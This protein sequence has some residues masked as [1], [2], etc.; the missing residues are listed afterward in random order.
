MKTFVLFMVTLFAGTAAFAQNDKPQGKEPDQRISVKKEYDDQ[1]NL[2]GYDASCV[3]SWSSDT[4]LAW[5]DMDAVRREMENFMKGGGF[6]SFFGDS[7]ESPDDLFGGL[8]QNFRKYFEDGLRDSALSLKDTAAILRHGPFGFSDPEKMR[9][10]MMK[11]FGQFFPGDSLG[12]SNFNFF[13]DPK[14]FEQIQ[15]EAEKHFGP[16]KNGD[17]KQMVQPSGKATPVVPI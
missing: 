7:L 11:E 6:G 12:G 2:I 13:F 14:E 1:G 4:T 17:G 3:R 15:K 5:G 8:R 10:R 16:R 9:E